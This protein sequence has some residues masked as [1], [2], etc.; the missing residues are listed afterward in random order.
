MQRLRSFILRILHFGRMIGRSIQLNRHFSVGRLWSG[1]RRWFLGRLGCGLR[2][3][4]RLL[5]FY[6]RGLNLVDERLVDELRRESFP[7]HSLVRLLN[8]TEGLGR[9]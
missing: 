5:E 1:H 3:P 7:I 9:L 2:N 8:R 6:E 4:E